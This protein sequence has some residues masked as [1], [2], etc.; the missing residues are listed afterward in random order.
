MINNTKSKKN[1]NLSPITDTLVKHFA[2]INVATELIAIFPQKVKI[3]GFTVIHNY[4]C[5]ER[6]CICYISMNVYNS[7]HKVFTNNIDLHVPN[8]LM[9]NIFVSGNIA[10]P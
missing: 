2:V 9:N 5:N 7:V 10:E 8:I 1:S 6:F 4:E 3:K